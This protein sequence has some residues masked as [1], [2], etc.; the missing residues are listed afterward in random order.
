M[1]MAGPF[2]MK[3]WWQAR[4]WG[5]N[6]R[7]EGLTVAKVIEFYIPTKFSKRVQW[8][9]PLQRGKVIE[10]SLQPKKSA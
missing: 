7:S 10:F 3:D 1:G 6:K 2:V 9:P 8:I 4:A 5:K